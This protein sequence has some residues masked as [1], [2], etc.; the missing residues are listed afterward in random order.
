M[1]DV[2]PGPVASPGRKIPWLKVALVASLAL[3]LLVI[4]AIAA[5]MAVH[6]PPG[7]LTGIS[8]VKL[9]PRKFFGDLG[10]GRRG[11]LMLILKGYRDE[12]RDGRDARKQLTVN[13]ANALDAEPY[14][15][16][17][18]KEA[19]AAFNAR[20]AGLVTRGGDA[21]L[22]FISRLTPEERKL[23]ANRIRERV[24]GDRHGGRD[25]GRD[26]D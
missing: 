24:P 3:N 21:A 18:V 9:I 22:D 19:V 23:L 14:D 11:E 26:G 12:F 25:G 1:S 10:M 17:K 16:A 2:T 7:R 6:E 15:E 20:S 8:E 5:R 13:L 4:G